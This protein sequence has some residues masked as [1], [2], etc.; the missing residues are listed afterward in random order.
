MDF[1]NHFVGREAE[2]AAFRQ[3]LENPYGEKRIALILGSGGIGKTLLVKELLQK[4][5]GQDILA[6]EEPIDLFSTDYRHIDGIQWKVREIIEDLT[7]LKGE[8]SLFAGYVKGKTDTSENFQN[9]LKRFCELHPLVLAFDTFENIDEV[10]GN[11]LFKNERGGLQV[12]GLICIIAGREE[13]RDENE[14]Y[15]YRVNH[16]VKEIRISGFTLSE[17]EEFYE[18]VEDEFFSPL[19]DDL[20]K[21]PGMEA[22]IP[23]HRGIEQIWKITKGHPLKLEMAFR[24]PGGL[25]SKNSLAGLTAEHF[26][27]KLMQYMREWGQQGSF[28]V[29]SLPVIQPVFDTLLCMAYINRRFDMQFLQFLID[30]KFIRF[31]DSDTRKKDVLDYLLRYFFVKMRG[32]SDE[33]LE[34]LQLHDEMARLVKMYIWPHIDLSGERRGELYMAVIR[35]Y[36]QLIGQSSENLGETFQIEQLYYMLQLD[37]NVGLQR[38]FELADLGNGNINKL[39]PGE[40]KDHIR[41]YDVEIQVQIHS[42]IAEMEKKA[43]HIR[44]ALGHWYEVGKLGEVAMRHDWVVD[45]LLGKFNC[46]YMADPEGALNN[47]LQPALAICERHLPKKLALIYY[48]IG[49]AYNQMQ[50]LN[51]AVAWYEKAMRQFQNYPDNSSLEATLY[52]NMG[53]AYLQIGM[54]GNTAKYLN[55]AL[56]IR[57]EQFIRDQKKLETVTKENMAALRAAHTQSAMFLGLSYNTLG[58]FHRFV[59]DLYEALAKY[60]EAN[61]IFLEIG[62]Y[63]WQAKCLCVRGETYRRL[64]KRTWQEQGASSAYQKDF[65][66]AHVDIETSLYL[67]EKYQFDDER[68]TAYRYLGRLTHDE[69]IVAIEVRD[70]LLASE[71]LEDAYLYF[72]QGLEFARN[73]KDALEELEILTELASLMGN[74]I[75]AYGMQKTPEYYYRAVDELKKAL[76]V[77]AHDPMRIYQYPVFTALLKMEQAAITYEVGDYDKALE[78]YLNAFKELGTFPGYGHA[79]YKQ[80]F[81]HLT[82]QIESLPK[83]EQARW[84]RR[85]VKV[86]KETGM[87]GRE[88]KTLADDLLP[89]LVKWCN[90]MLKNSE[91]N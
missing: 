38:W 64:G 4:A 12:P 32:I 9:C 81:G 57:L 68:D 30:E 85:F 52:N 63:F 75:A 48:E 37:K 66:Q 88:D 27:E 58:E 67:F 90:R 56:D 59:G 17:A 54:W 47:Y 29:G 10:T 44:Q 46:T 8:L 78:L 1:T 82:K 70:F 72:Q 42:R 14:L 24:W 53:Y 7:G 79:R 40:I 73:T 60:N 50:K 76:N 55:E 15:Y 77:H 41:N 22:S 19:G 62:D 2:L 43:S 87:P 74:A 21:A 45:S 91:K 23:I 6:P 89:D 25:L 13:N 36:N 20:L 83:E 16:L 34:I 11:W 61:Q 5:R 33:G 71:K 39:L 28:M 18:R 65:L 69:A 3:L 49:F 51:L 35:F 80:N 86:W 26:E 31:G 84:C